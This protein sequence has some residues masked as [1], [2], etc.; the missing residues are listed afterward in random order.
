V[1][2]FT[3]PL[4]YLKHIQIYTTTLALK[5][6]RLLLR[7]FFFPPFC[8]VCQSLLD[9][10]KVLC[11]SC[12]SQIELCEDR[13]QKRIGRG[14][15]GEHSFLEASVLKNAPVSSALVKK[16]KQPAGYFLSKALAGYV[17]LRVV[18]LGWDVE[19]IYAEKGLE[20]VGRA[21]SKLIGAGFR[22]KPSRAK[23]SVSASA[24]RCLFL[25]ASQGSRKK[26]LTGFS[27]NSLHVLCLVGS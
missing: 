9:E 13:A 21:L 6:L 23:F 12:F 17:G 22:K 8:A 20:G 26:S 3:S 25:T 27:K 10:E 1:H 11:S 19:A 2:I 14:E 5:K 16:A 18:D 24:Q 7:R 4:C 15:Q